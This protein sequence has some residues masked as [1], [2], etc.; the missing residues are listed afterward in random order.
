MPVQWNA[1]ARR[2]RGEIV[3]PGDE[4]YE[5]ARRLQNLEYDAINPAAVVYCETAQDVGASIEFARSGGIDVHVRSGGHSLNGLSTG[6]GM[7]LD[8]SRING[9]A[10]REGTVALG[11]GTQSLDALDVLAGTG[12]QIITGTFPTVAAGGFLSGGGIGWQTRGFGIG[13]DRVRS[14]TVVL[15]D[16]R[17][18]TCSAESEPDLL[19]ALRGGGGGNFGVVTEFEVAP[20]DAPLLV[21]YEI[22]W[23]VDVAADVLTSWQ[24]WCTAG[25]DFGS[26][27]VVLP[28]FGPD[29]PPA[30][31]VWGVHY[32]APHGIE[33]ALD[34]L[35][36]LA[37]T[38][39]LRRWVGDQLPYS[40]VMHERL[41]GEATV[42]QCHRTGSGPE[43]KGHRHP[44]TRQA[45]RLLADPVTPEQA[46]RSLAM[47]ET[48]PSWERYL[49]CIAVGGPTGGPE[50]AYPHRD[51]R[52]L[53]GYQIAVRDQGASAEHFADVTTWADGA[54]EVLDPMACG[55]YI[56][57]PSSRIRKGWARAYHRDA[58]P[59]L[60]EVKAKYDPDDVF[61]HAQ[62]LRP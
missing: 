59:R 36:E 53:M 20:I 43:A 61:R 47:W 2:L 8:V 33:R 38:R 24:T 51:A 1:L 37:G 7:V 14:A 52:F 31:K 4:R 11:A 45:Y 23:D 22:T 13:S 28:R 48:S 10:V 35:V 25:G 56:N 46:G 60:L 17:I 49:L 55:S 15:A 34:D 9:V 41:C 44:H 54:D 3:R 57:F 29:A 42:A 30:V 62:S 50:S 18:A 12:K 58:L 21:G 19:W 6:A 16:G 27:L 32:G 26:S 5:F 40:T 39:P